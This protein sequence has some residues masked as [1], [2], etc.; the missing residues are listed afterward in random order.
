MEKIR[1]NTE[2]PYDVWIGSGLLSR[3]GQLL[4]ENL[5]KRGGKAVV[6]TDENVGPLYYEKVK[7]ELENCGFSV[8]KAIVPAGEEAKSGEQYLRLLSFLAANH[9]SRGDVIFALGGG[10]P[11]DLSG[12]LAATFLRG[13]H[14]VQLP[15]TLLAA[16]DSSV[17]GKTAINLP[18]GKNL[19]GAFYQPSAVILDT[20]ALD[21]LSR[22]VFTD[23]CAE[24]IKYAMIRDQE[25]F[26]LLAQNKLP[27][28]RGNVRL[29]ERVI[30][31]CVEI[32][33]QVVSM[34]EKD[35]GLR[36]LLNFGHTV[37]H[38]VEKSSGFSVSHGK[39][40][41]IGMTA[42]CRFAEKEKICPPGVTETLKELL[43]YYD[44]PVSAQYPAETIC[45]GIL[46]DKKIE[47]NRLHFILP[48]NIGD[49]FIYDMEISQ[50]KDFLL[51][52]DLNGD[53]V[54]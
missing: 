20:D 10:V 2:K 40:V 1:I 46:S 31:R 29:I 38:A 51:A 42:A 16:V 11:G 21:T 53:T 23:G 33:R 48:R 37:G 44:L 54:R 36:N 43:N 25:L 30:S 35:K 19:A 41:A 22:D 47:G 28:C 18:E 9:V 12:F 49:C 15:T 5:L 50:L 26:A 6:I 45:E 52:E 27:E 7:K 39:A 13:I 4:P 17:G 3:F 34:D 32:K 24:V 8:I 14:F